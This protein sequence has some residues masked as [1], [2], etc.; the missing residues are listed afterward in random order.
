[1]PL[2]QFVLPPLLQ[3]AQCGRGQPRRI[4]AQESL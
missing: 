4:G 1:L 3:P 2:G